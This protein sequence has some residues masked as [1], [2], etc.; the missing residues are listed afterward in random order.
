MKDIF[1]QIGSGAVIGMIIFAIFALP[2]LDIYCSEV[3]G[4][5]YGFIGCAV[6]N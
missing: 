3:L 5:E 2:V 4:S 6:G 1:K